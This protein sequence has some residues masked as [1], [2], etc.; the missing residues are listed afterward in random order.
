MGVIVEADNCY[1]EGRRFHIDDKQDK[2]QSKNSLIPYR[3]G[4]RTLQMS[5]RHASGGRTA[6]PLS[7]DKPQCISQS[8][9]VSSCL[10]RGGIA[11][12]SRRPSWW[13][14]ALPRTGVREALS[15]DR[16]E[17]PLVARWVQR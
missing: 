13:L 5:A 16:D 2:S 15:R 9:I 17:V 12:R 7:V 1:V 14:V 10:C 6:S 11:V 8:P 3:H 4:S